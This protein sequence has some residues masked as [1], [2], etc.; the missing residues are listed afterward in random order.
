MS[1]LVL[2]PVSGME[3]DRTLVL[4]I[5]QV[6]PRWTIRGFKDDFYDIDA[7]VVLLAGETHLRRKTVS[8]PLRSRAH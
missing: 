3:L 1:K 7:D 4:P 2:I 6:A 8:K 5:K